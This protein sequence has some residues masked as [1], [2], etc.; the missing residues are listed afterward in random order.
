M[1]SAEGAGE[2]RPHADGGHRPDAGGVRGGDRAHPWKFIDSRL[3]RF[4]WFWITPNG[5]WRP[6]T[7]AFHM[8]ENRTEEIPA[9]GKT[10][11]TANYCG[12]AHWQW[13]GHYRDGKLNLLW[14]P[15][16][17]LYLLTGVLACCGIVALFVDRC[18]RPIAIAVGTLLPCFA[19]LTA[20]GAP[21]EYRYRMI[22]EP[23]FIVCIAQL[24]NLL[25]RRL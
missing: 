25:V 4:A 3:R 24:A 12:Q 21:P 8:Y 13:D 10:L 7:R 20:V 5:T 11:E 16:P 22:L 6:L 23:M 19:A 1:G 9:L 18:H 15:N 2:A 17:W 14:H